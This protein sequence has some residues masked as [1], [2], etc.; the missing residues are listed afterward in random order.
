MNE[1]NEQQ[2]RTIAFFDFDGTLSESDSLWPFL[3]AVV[4]TPAC[5]FALL[6]GS[7][8]YLFPCGR[9]RRTVVK[10][11]LL[12]SVL[13]G[14]TMR[15]LAPAIERMKSWPRWM[16][17]V[18]DIRRHYAAGHHV[19]IATGSL[20]LYI[21]EMLG[22]L[23]YHAIL[24]TEMEIKEGVLTGK[25]AKGNC[26]RK[27]KAERVAEYLLEHGPFVDSWAYG[28]APHDLPMMAL[29]NH[30]VIV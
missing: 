15:M 22:D 29:T 23:P 14:K 11:I 20:N 25:M 5:L 12:S 4:G 27:R 2:G 10:E 30:R 19:V 17:S 3:V 9:D 13:R 6:K 28:N 21:K 7:V 24:S 16:K 1:N 26:V 8:F 18:D